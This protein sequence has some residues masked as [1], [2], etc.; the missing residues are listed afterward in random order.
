ML[1][2]GA[3]ALILLGFI[4]D[5]LFRR[6]TADVRARLERSPPADA[7]TTAGRI[8]L[9]TVIDLLAVAVFALAIYGTFFAVAGDDSVARR[10]VA[11]YVA[12]LV[13]V[14]LVDVLVRIPLAPYAPGLRLVSMSDDAAR[15]LRRWIV[16]VAAVAAFGFLTCGLIRL[17][18]VSDDVHVLTVTMVGTGVAAMLLALIWHSRAGVARAI[19]G[20]QPADDAP[21]DASA[22][23]L[24]GVLADLWPLFASLYVALI[25]ALWSVNLLT[26]RDTVAGAGVL[27]IVIVAILP[28]VDR[29]LRQLLVRLV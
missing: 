19:G 1:V 17:L 21:D 28:L 23:R 22:G 11:T 8:L 4:A 13:I 2:A 5:R 18:G 20:G 9:R 10:F 29:G 26:G 15:Y 3:A 14:R 27:S 25:W 12:A 6:L 16:S 7:A 24:R